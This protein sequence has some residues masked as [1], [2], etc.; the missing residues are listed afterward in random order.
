MNVFDI[1]G[2]VM[3][4][5]SSSHTAGAVRIGRMA[6]LIL[7]D[8][9]V[10]AHIKLFG[11]FS[12]T[13]KGHG[14]DRALAGGLLGYDVDDERINDSLGFAVR[15][16]VRIRFETVDLEQAHP[17]TA[18]I[19]LT[20]KSGRTVCVT[21]S[22]IGGGNIIIT[23]I[24]GIRV[25]LSGQY[26]TLIVKHNDTS[27]I[28]AMVTEILASANINIAFMK[29]FRTCKGGSAIMVI[30]ADQ[31]VQEET[32]IWISGIPQVSYASVIKPVEG[33]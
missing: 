23:E 20:G 17:N 10:E 9:P 24:D 4:G 11:S 26:Y 22:S 2:P 7:A 14:T 19:E 12:K 33:E 29:D 6:R 30:E 8:E 13:Y 5:P 25:E 1:I 18:C 15:Q 3:V 31:P 16:G 27:G 28:I 21:G 32:A